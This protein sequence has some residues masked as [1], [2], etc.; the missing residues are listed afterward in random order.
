MTFDQA[1][2]VRDERKRG[3]TM[4]EIAQDFKEKYGGPWQVDDN[5]LVGALL[6]DEAQNMLGGEPFDAETL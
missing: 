6:I 3:R 4:R 2:Y 5:Q 1:E